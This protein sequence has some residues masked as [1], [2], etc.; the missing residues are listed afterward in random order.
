MGL[1]N[2]SSV[3][4]DND[5]LF[6]V[7]VNNFS[8]GGLEQ[9]NSQS[10]SLAE[11][12]KRVLSSAICLDKHPRTRIDLSFDVFNSESDLSSLLSHLINLGSY[13]LLEAG[14]N[15]KD[16]VTSCVTCLDRVSGNFVLDPSAKEKKDSEFSLVLA[17]FNTSGDISYF[18]TEGKLALGLENGDKLSEGLS[19]AVSACGRI[20]TKLLELCDTHL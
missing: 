19:L 1:S 10:N 18:K 11:K 4:N 14:V 17:S 13:V 15:T 7:K 3:S 9:S 16:T 8:E 12:L 6:E 2:D 20:S 5:A